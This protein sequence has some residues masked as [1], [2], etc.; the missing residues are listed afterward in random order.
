MNFNERMKGNDMMFTGFVI[1]AIIGG[2]I[3]AS[4]KTY[5]KKNY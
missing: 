2:F 3:G 5:F 4:A 1:G